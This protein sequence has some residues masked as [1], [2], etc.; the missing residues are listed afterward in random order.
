MRLNP[1]FQRNLW[2]EL[3]VTRLIAAP[4]ILAAA[5]L[6]G[7]QLN[8]VI[9]LA[10]AAEILFFLVAV[11]WGSRRAAAA[12]GDEVSAATWDGQRMSALSAWQMTWG[13]LFGSTAFIW[14]C[15]LICLGAGL[16]AETLALGPNDAVRNLLS[17][18]FS[19]LLAQAVALAACLVFLRK[20][21]PTRRVPV[22]LCQGLGVLV[23]ISG[24]GLWRGLN[25]ALSQTRFQD[26]V[27]YG[28]TYHSPSFTLVV[29]AVFLAWAFL[30]VYRL[31]RA[32]LQF[33]SRPWAWALFTV[34][35]AAFVQG[36]SVID[37]DVRGILSASSLFPAFA[38]A[39]ALIYVALF[40]EPKSSVAYRGLL[41]ALRIRDWRTAARRIPL[42]VTSG[43]IALPLGVGVT[44]QLSK[45]VPLYLDTVSMI[46]GI[47]AV[48]PLWV[49]V[50]LLLVL[51]DVG[52]LLFLNFGRWQRRA[53]LAGLVY[54]VVVYGLIPPLLFAAEY[55]A[56]V[57]LLIALPGPVGGP[58]LAAALFQALGVGAGLWW[59][60]RRSSGALL[61]LRP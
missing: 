7:H 61:E 11:L 20:M 59:R 55:D 43:L 57:P 53:D 42:W 15:A 30:G 26:I 3:S 24:E 31:I 46:S 13:K 6:L 56:L 37:I 39:C 44:V 32:E 1:E 25:E 19:S 40:L 10:R 22:T 51:R 45:G 54:L 58:V 52:V 4:L 27:W 23:G 60:L 34:F 49:L 14:F 18:L 5:L 41:S 47:T 17:R 28:E 48:S 36:F 21:R 9:G 50:A 12:L 35:M 38:A 29:Q 8:P 16:W 2:I 33:P